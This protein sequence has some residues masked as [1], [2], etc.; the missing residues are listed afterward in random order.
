MTT[1]HLT[2]AQRMQPPFAP[3]LGQTMWAEHGFGYGVRIRTSQPGIG[4]STGTVSWPGGFG[5][6]WYADPREDLVALILL[7]SQNLIVAAD[8]RSTIGDDFLTHTYN[9]LDD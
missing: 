3:P 7:Q 6:A 4:P 9:A 8:W 2:T 1:D 5:T